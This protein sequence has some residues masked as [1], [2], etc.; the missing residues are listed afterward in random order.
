MI[1]Q[2]A[3]YGLIA[4]GVLFNNYVYL[5]DLVFD[6]HGGFIYVGW[7]SAAGI[8]IGLGMVGLGVRLLTPSS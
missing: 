1:Q 4:A 7:W 6:K 5:H 8:L 2:S 3:G